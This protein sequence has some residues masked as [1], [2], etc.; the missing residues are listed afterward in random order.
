MVNTMSNLFLKNFQKSY[1][2][3]IAKTAIPTETEDGGIIGNPIIAKGF[4]VDADDDFIYL[5]RTPIQIDVA[6]KKADILLVEI[7]DPDG[8]EELMLNPE[9][10]EELN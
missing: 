3:I 7:T 1:V 8:Y 2:E 5:G 9:H 4:V 6:I 10:D